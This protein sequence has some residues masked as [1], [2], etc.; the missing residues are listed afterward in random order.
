M[1]IVTFWMTAFCMRLKYNVED[2][3]NCGNNS[4]FT[5]PVTVK[6]MSLNIPTLRVHRTI[7]EQTSWLLLLTLCH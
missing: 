6:A 5:I 2:I 3:F 1:A 7:F 4:K